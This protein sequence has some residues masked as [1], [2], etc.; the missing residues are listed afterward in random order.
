M[1]SV[2]SHL[3]RYSVLSFSIKFCLLNTYQ[4]SS[5]HGIVL[6]ITPKV[7]FLDSE[8]EKSKVHCCTV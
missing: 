1:G 7:R 5:L 8:N 4:L 2:S 6:C 3:R